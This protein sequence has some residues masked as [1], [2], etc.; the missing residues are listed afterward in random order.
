MKYLWLRLLNK[1]NLLKNHN[2]TRKVKRNN[3]PIKI[4]I[5]AAVGLAN[6]TDAEPWMTEVLK[7]LQTLSTGTFLDIGVNIGQT[8]I[9]F[10][11]IDTNSPY[12]GL[13]PN[14]LAVAYVSKLIQIN[15]FKNCTILPVGISDQNKVLELNIYS[16]SDYDSG[17]SIISDFRDQSTIKKKLYV[18]IY[19]MECLQQTISFDKVSLIKIDVEGAELEVLKS[20]TPLLKERRPSIVTEILPV[21]DAEKNTTRKSRQ[22]QIE[23]LVQSID[24]SIYRILKTDTGLLKE[25]L[26]IDTIGVHSDLTHCDYIFLPNEYNEKL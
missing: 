26:K 11:S 1:F 7:K 4:P 20:L 8:L 16:D 14:P 23:E 22:D 5:Q 13:E 18:P 19:D 9:K 2:I 12:I 24:Y 15:N 10:R 6:L 21:Y 17:A 25:I 3:Q